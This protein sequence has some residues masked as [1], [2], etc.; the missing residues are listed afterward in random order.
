LLDKRVLGVARLLEG[1]VAEIDVVADRERGDIRANGVDRP[2][3]I[4]PNDVRRRRSVV[5]VV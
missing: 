1:T 4:E 2:C 3:A 5:I